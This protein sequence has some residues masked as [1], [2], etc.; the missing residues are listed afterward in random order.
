MI[1]LSQTNYFYPNQINI[2]QRNGVR[3][4]NELLLCIPK[5]YIDRSAILNLDTAGL[6]DVVTFIG[7]II[8][9]EI[10]FGRKRRL[11]LKCSYQD[12]FIEV[13]FFQGISYHQKNFHTGLTVAF[14]G[15]LDVFAGKPS[16]THPEFE[17]ISGEDLI[18]TGKIVP[19]YR[20]TQGMR[21]SFLTTKTLRKII[22]KI[23]EDYHDKI[24]D[25][26][27]EEILKTTGLLNIRDAL[28]KVHFPNE[29]SDTEEARKR[30]AFDEILMFTIL[31]KERKLERQK[32]KKKNIASMQ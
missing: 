21:N 30:L 10:K 13:I 17:I 5:R 32:L 29:F 2:L 20:V 24:Y 1:P 18:H 22:H 11:V 7:K 12:H 14:S 28:L 23:L 6:G 3:T 19:L 27:P 16:M 8:S 15:T 26:L 9:K 25:Y 4:I 31:M